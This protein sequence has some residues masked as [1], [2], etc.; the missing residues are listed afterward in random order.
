MA[1]RSVTVNITNVDEPGTVNISSPN[2]EVKVGVQLTAELDDGDEETV[3]GW[4]WASGG[5]NTGPLERHLRR[6]E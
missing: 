4:Q 6:D 2:N 5:S 3:I 1:T